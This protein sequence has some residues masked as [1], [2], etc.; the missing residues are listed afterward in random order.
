MPR[1]SGFWIWC[2]RAP[3]CQ[4]TPFL[5]TN[6]SFSTKFPTS[7]LTILHE[8]RLEPAFG[9]TAGLFCCARFSTDKPVTYFRSKPQADYGVAVVTNF[10]QTTATT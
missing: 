4:L 9:S 5:L 1:P 2:A 8:C 7:K 6:A 3:L 10:Q